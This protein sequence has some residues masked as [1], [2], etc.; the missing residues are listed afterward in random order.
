MAKKIRISERVIGFG[1]RPYIVAEMSGNH[2]S[3]L[4]YALEMMEAASD[5]G[6]DAVKLQTYTPDTL[7]IDYDGE[8]FRI[9][10]GLWDGRTLYDLY[11]EAHTPWSMHKAL[12]SRGRELG[13]DVFSTPFDETAVRF[14]DDLNTP[15]HKV[16]SFEMTDWELLRCIAKS[17]K[18]VI[19]STGMANFEEITDSV[20][21]LRNENE[22]PIVLLHCISAYP[23][24]AEEANL[25]TMCDLAEKLNLPVGLSD[26]TLGT[27]VSVAAV[28][29]GACV[30]EKHFTLSRADGGPDSAFSLEP[31]ELKDLVE[32]CQTAYEALG[33]VS[34]NRQPS[35][36]GN[37]TFRRSVYI[38]K[39]VAKGEML[40]RENTRVIRPGYGLAPKFISEV[41]GKVAAQD[42]KRGDALSWDKIDG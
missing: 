15:I 38:V 36:K 6:V 32:Q 31:H 8:D 40:T 9:Q 3:D 35:E 24:P 28:A 23:A 17:R 29:L 7:T 5:A 10:G 1:E 2:Q 20:N 37:I 14:L 33:S 13:I 16:A 26:H 30:I 4:S 11:E 25:R 21:V 22:I 34:Y 39:D 41:L 27:T 18:P 19:M 42:L 12:F